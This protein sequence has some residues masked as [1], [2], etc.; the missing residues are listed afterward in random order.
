MTEDVSAPDGFVREI[1]ATVAE[2]ERGLRLAVPDGVARPQPGHLRVSVAGTQLSI[3]VTERPERRLG[4]FR[5]LVL[6][7]RYRFLSGDVPA[8]LALLAHL[9]RAMQRG[10]G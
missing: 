7:A 1:G 6:L 4:Q 5:L 8:R 2:F 3:E 10:G 9:D